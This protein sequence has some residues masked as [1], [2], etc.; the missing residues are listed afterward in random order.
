MDPFELKSPLSPEAEFI[1]ELVQE[2]R[3]S[4]NLSDFIYRKNFQFI[5]GSDMDPIETV[6]MI[7]V[8]MKDKRNQL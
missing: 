7:R 4:Y 5:I 3:R 2:L 8:A 1:K 6:D